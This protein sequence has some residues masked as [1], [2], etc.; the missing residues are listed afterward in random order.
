MSS[1]SE[2]MPLKN[3]RDEQCIKRRSLRQS[4]GTA[5]VWEC[6]GWEDKSSLPEAAP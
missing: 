3:E 4:K 6:R 5:G 2:A 1:A